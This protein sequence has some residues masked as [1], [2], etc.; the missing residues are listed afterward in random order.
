MQTLTLGPQ[1]PIEQELSRIAAGRQHTA[2]PVDADPFE[3]TCVL[4][5][6]IDLAKS[7]VY[8]EFDG[9]AP[10]E[11]ASITVNGTH[12]GGFIGKPFRLDITQHLKAGSNS[13]TI[14]PFAPKSAKLVVY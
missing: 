5:P 14:V 7:R 13:I 8:L 9:L 12:A 6:D 3:G 10:E 4:P 1:S 11:A 2:S